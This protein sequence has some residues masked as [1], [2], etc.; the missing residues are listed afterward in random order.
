MFVSIGKSWVEGEA[1]SIEG[2]EILKIIWIELCIFFCFISVNKWELPV[3]KNIM[4]TPLQSCWEM[5]KSIFTMCIAYDR[6][7]IN[8]NSLSLNLNLYQSLRTIIVPKFC[9]ISSFYEIIIIYFNHFIVANLRYDWSWNLSKVLNGNV[10]KKILIFQYVI[11]CPI[12]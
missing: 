8:I 10:E 11:Q 1:T 3:S 6:H 5:N 12:Y 2:S 7:S 4:K 9:V